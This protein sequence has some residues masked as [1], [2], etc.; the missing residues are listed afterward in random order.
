MHD[1]VT[2]RRDFVLPL[3]RHATIVERCDA[4]RIVK[5]LAH[6]ILTNGKSH[7]QHENERECAENEHGVDSRGANRHGHEYERKYA[8]RYVDKVAE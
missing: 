8:Q 2:M 5:R 4:L 3:A 6:D 1:V 7:H